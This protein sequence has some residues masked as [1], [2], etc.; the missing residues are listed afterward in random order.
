[1]T[2]EPEDYRKTSANIRAM[3]SPM[4]TASAIVKVRALMESFAEP[5]RP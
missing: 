1:M 4:T 2:S 5:P 3:N